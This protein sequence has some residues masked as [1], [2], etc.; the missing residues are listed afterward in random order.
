MCWGIWSVFDPDLCG[1]GIVKYLGQFLSLIGEHSGCDL[2]KGWVVTTHTLSQRTLEE[3]GFLPIGYFPGGEL[4][5]GEDGMCYRH[6]VIWYEKIFQKGQARTMSRDY[7]QLLDGGQGARV[8]R[9]IQAIWDEALNK[10][11]NIREQFKDVH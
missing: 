9:F 11:E 8:A 1:L 7:E 6:N 4:F 5:A 2:V 3:A 10:Q